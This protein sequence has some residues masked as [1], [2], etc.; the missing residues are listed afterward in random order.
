[1]CII[2]YF[3]VVYFAQRNI[4]FENEREGFSVAVL[5]Y[6]AM[7]EA[8]GSGTAARVESHAFF[9][10]IN[11]HERGLMGTHE[12]IYTMKIGQRI[13]AV[14]DDK[15]KNFTVNWFAAEL[16]CDR[17]NIYRIFSKENIDIH[18]LARI[19][20]ILDHDFFADLSR[21]LKTAK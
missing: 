5:F 11:A 9:L 14:F 2:P 4:A 15:P 12:F 10:C 13:K 18:L 16:N 7:R 3:A 6:K 17:R 8:S 1:M 20:V 21:E 19:S